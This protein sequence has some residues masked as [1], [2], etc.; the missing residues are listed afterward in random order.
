MLP[1]LIE[2]GICVSEVAMQWHGK[3]C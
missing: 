1:G 2:A 3:T